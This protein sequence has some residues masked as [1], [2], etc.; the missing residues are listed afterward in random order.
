MLIIFS[1]PHLKHT[2][3]NL[4]ILLCLYWLCRSFEM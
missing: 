2:Q 1:T 3:I 4:T